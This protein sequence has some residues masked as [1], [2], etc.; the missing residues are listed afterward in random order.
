MNEL[1]DNLETVLTTSRFEDGKLVEVRL[2]PADLGQ[3]RTRPISRSGTP[4][5]PS[6]EMALR[7]LERLQALSKQFGTTISIQNG[8]GVIRIASKQG[9]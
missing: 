4:S 6:P 5:T 2:Y 8:V 9:N 1:E 7:V 3:D